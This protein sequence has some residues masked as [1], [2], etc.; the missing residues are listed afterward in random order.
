MA[1]DGTVFE[2]DRY[3]TGGTATGAAKRP[4]TI[5]GTDFPSVYETA[6]MTTGDEI[7]YSL[8]IPY[9]VGDSGH[10][11]DFVLTLK[12]VELRYNQTGK[13]QFDVNLNGLPVLTGIDIVEEVGKSVA[14]DEDIEFRVEPMSMLLWVTSV[15]KMQVRMEQP[16]SF[17]LTSEIHV[18]ITPQ[19]GSARLCALQ[20][21]QGTLAELHAHRSRKSKKGSGG[22]KSR[23]RKRTPNS[24]EREYRSRGD[25]E[26]MNFM[27]N[28][29][30]YIFGILSI[31][32]ASLYGYK[33]FD[34]SS[35]PGPP[36]SVVTQRQ[37]HQ[38]NQ[39][40]GRNR[41][42]HGS[43]TPIPADRASAGDERVLSSK[44]SSTS[45][46]SESPGPPPKN[47]PKKVPLSPEEEAKQAALRAEK[48]EKKR[49][50]VEKAREE[51]RRA[52]ELAVAKAKADRESA[53]ERS[54][55][56]LKLLQELEKQQVKAEAEARQAREAARRIQAA[57]KDKEAKEENE[58]TKNKSNGK[59]NGDGM[60]ASSL[61][62]PRSNG[63]ATASGG[64][65]AATVHLAA[66]ITVTL[67]TLAVAVP[68]N[69]K[70]DSNT[71]RSRLAMPP[72]LLD[73][74]R[75]SMCQGLLPGP[76]WTTAMVALAVHQLHPQTFGVCK[77]CPSLPRRKRLG[78]HPVLPALAAS[79]PI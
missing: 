32:A 38:R 62:P 33:R 70:V 22:K 2:Q 40:D 48:K 10:G 45:G 35:R 34:G 64:G 51:S 63:A 73:L 16:A 46:R 11:W 25:G 74:A 69:S 31:T 65:G 66:T 9:N 26:D 54:A 18:G 21:T 42:A 49:I 50:K 47:T 28:P 61:K 8:P 71:L 1:P 53:L 36:R 24:S 67:P 15:G 13:R 78:V 72:L 77:G 27:Q 19:I 20:V 41:T 5:N 52:E 6:R 12:F 37:E 4:V 75:Q 23:V 79:D 30:G 56:A 44:T 59:K 68:S 43:H 29:F 60:A 3:Y 58:S 17:G 57:T 14:Y 55:S 76:P 7:W 39:H